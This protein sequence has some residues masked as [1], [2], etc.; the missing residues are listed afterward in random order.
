MCRDLEIDGD[1]PP[2]WSTSAGWRR[3]W[4]D[5][6]K[7]AYELRIDLT[8]EALY[9][10]PEITGFDA[11][12]TSNKPFLYFTYSA[13]CSEVEIDVLTGEFDIRRTDILYDAGRSL[14]PLIDTGQI[15]GGFVQ[16]LGNLTTE[17][18]YY[19]DS[20]GD[21]A[22]LSSN[23]WNYK[24]PCSKAIPAEFNTSIFQYDND[25]LNADPRLPFAVWRSKSTGEPP[26]VLANSVFF[27][28][29]RAVAAARADQDW[30]DWFPFDA[31]AT[32]V[33]IQRAC[34]EEGAPERECRTP[35][36]DAA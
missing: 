30:K 21:G 13:A 14:N 27:A 35:Q 6:V 33:K 16:G 9:R 36:A 4:P 19:D 26:A 1:A 10:S 7:K 18:I 11:H 32:V 5:I 29:R 31:P 3:A 20:H 2:C 34:R 24:P 17:E 28:I 8:A 23:F 12:S 25:A 22:P 15:E